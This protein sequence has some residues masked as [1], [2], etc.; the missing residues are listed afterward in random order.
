MLSLFYL[1]SFDSVFIP[2]AS[3]CL[4]FVI[5][6]ILLE[7]ELCGIILPL[8]TDSV[9]PGRYLWSSDFLSCNLLLL[10][11]IFC[12]SKLETRAIEWPVV[13]LLSYK[14]WRLDFES[15]LSLARYT[16]SYRVLSYWSVC[17]TPPD[18]RGTRGSSILPF[19]CLNLSPT[20]D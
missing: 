2:P 19:F 1:E 9:E 4:L 6:A 16:D 8:L 10:A 7:M 11:V 17:D 12:P 14:G 5:R 18:I 3:Y 20:Y 15:W 13:F